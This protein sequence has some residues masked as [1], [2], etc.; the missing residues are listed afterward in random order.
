[1]QG[2]F[3]PRTPMMRGLPTNPR[4]QVKA[5]RRRLLLLPVPEV[6]WRYIGEA[7]SGLAF[8]SVTYSQIHV[9]NRPRLSREAKARVL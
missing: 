3:S 6:E 4:L 8:K 2:I 9:L 7:C 5:C 1:M